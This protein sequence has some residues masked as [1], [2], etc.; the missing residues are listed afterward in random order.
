MLGESPTTNDQAS[1]EEAETVIPHWI[2]Q[3]IIRVNTGQLTTEQSEEEMQ[4]V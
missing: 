1:Y 3:L 4:F 2:I